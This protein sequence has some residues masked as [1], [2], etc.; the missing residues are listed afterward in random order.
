MKPSFGLR[1]SRAE[2]LSR[3]L[4]VTVRDYPETLPALR[5]AGVS[6]SDRGATSLGA[7]IGGDSSLV[8]D[9]V[10]AVAWRPTG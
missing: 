8:D 7:M 4:H 5:R 9:L 2:L 3:P 6:L 1:P 10:E